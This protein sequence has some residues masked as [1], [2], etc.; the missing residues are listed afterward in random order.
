VADQSSPPD[1]PV[2]AVFAHPDDAEISAGGTLARW[3]KEGRAVHLLVLTNGDRGSEDPAQDQAELARIRVAETEAAGRVLGLA[4][5]RVLDV[6]DGELENTAAVRAEVVRTIR[7]VKPAIV[8]TC[9]PTAWFFGN[10]YFNHAD[11][12][13]AGA[14][15]LDAVFPGAGNPLFFTEQLA[16][17]LAPWKVTEVWLGWTI[18]PNHHQD[19]TGFMETKLDALAAHKS[20]VEGDMLGFFREWLPKEA[21]ENGAKIGVEHAEAFRV[22][23]LD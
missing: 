10:R 11:H 7:E 5:C 14:T 23:N 22:L 1:G 17:G 18:E 9:D 8:V 20:Q 6:H 12:R 3:A 4:G 2:L 21:E 19:V 16:E 15:A 13:T